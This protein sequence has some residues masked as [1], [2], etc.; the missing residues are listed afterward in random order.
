MDKRSKF[1]I[2]QRLQILASPR[3]E[4]T[5]SKQQ[6]CP[7][8]KGFRLFLTAALLAG[9]AMSAIL[10]PVARANEITVADGVVDIA[11]DGQ[12]SLKEAIINANDDAATHPDCPPGNGDDT[13]NLAAG[14]TYTLATVDNETDGPNGLPSI[15]SQITIN[16]NGATIQRDP[17]YAC[18][19]DGD[20]NDFRIFHVESTGNLTLNELTVSSGCACD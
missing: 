19:E 8:I 11:I 5:T 6:A 3:R 1:I 7:I 16:G 20:D 18:P 2:T 4:K 12:C 10:P 14:A 9:M 15:T 17:S 13:I